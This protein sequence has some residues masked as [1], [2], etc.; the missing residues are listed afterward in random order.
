[1]GITISSKNKSIYLGYGGFYNFRTKVAEL[2]DPELLA[3]YKELDKSFKI[4]SSEE[5]K[6]FFENY[7][8][9]IQKFDE[10][11]DGK[12]SEVLDFLYA[13][14]CDAEFDADHCKKIYEIIKDYDDNILYGYVGRKNCAKFSDFKAVILDGTNNNGIEWF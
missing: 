5:R 14:D 10:D 11:H 8:K 2:T 3:L 4:L 12:Y 7:N 9:Q 6:T 13:S 1:M